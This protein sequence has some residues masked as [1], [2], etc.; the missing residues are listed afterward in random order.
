MC[1]A[2]KGTTFLIIEKPF[3]VRWQLKFVT[4]KLFN[5]EINKLSPSFVF[6]INLSISRAKQKMSF[7]NFYYIRHPY[8]KS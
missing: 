5:I 7:N 6:E 3:N 1:Q 8:G 2:A 4:S